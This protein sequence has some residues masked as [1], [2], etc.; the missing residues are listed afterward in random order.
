MKP[1]A[2]SFSCEVFFFFKHN[3]VFV[4]SGHL[5]TCLLLPCLALFCWKAPALC[6]PLC[7]QDKLAFMTGRRCRSSFWNITPNWGRQTKKCF[8]SSAGLRSRVLGRLSLFFCPELFFS[9][10]AC[11][12]CLP[13]RGRGFLPLLTCPVILTCP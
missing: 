1:S 10:V 6:S 8:I 2:V 5:M 3:G 13:A 4:V 11:R 9:G 7:P 12:L